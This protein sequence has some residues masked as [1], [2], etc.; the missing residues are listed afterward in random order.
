MSYPSLGNSGCQFVHVG[1]N[2]Y[3]SACPQASAVFR[4]AMTS[5]GEADRGHIG[6]ERG[7]DPRRAVLDDQTA[8]RRCRQTLRSMQKQV[9]RR[10][11]AC[12]HCRAEQVFAKA[13]QESGQL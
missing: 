2:Q 6:G 13:A 12:D 7:I 8:V 9:R 10:L 3:R 11:T 5:P 4:P 1:N